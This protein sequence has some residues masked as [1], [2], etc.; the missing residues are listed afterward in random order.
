MA[1]ACSCHGLRDAEVLDVIREGA[2]SVGDVM[3]QC[4]AG[5]NC[6]S[7]VS[8]IEMLLAVEGA[9]DAADAVSAA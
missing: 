3:D 2:C 5:G 4:D 6:G 8:T 7:C 1:I 9:L